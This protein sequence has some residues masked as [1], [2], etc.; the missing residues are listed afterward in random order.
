MGLYP[1]TPIVN[2]AGLPAV[3]LPLGHNRDGLPIG[4][5]LIAQMCGEATLFR[6][7]SQLESTS[8]WPIR[9]PPFFIGND[10]DAHPKTEHFY[11]PDPAGNPNLE[12]SST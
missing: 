8:L 7:A 6:V 3:S 10:D 5:Q 9:R 4:I 12:R 1:L 2:V 11:P